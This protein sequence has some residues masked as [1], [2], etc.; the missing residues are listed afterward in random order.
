MSAHPLSTRYRRPLTQRYIEAVDGLLRISSVPV[1][2][3]SDQPPDAMR[4]LEPVP[5]EYHLHSA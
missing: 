2:F 5:T 4:F 1:V 3:I